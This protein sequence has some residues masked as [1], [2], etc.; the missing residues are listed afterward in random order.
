MLGGHANEERADRERREVGVEPR[1]S[2][3]HERVPDDPPNQA[4][5]FDWGDKWLN[6]EE[7]YHI[8]THTDL[9][10]RVYGFEKY[11][12]KTHPESTYT[13]PTSSGR[14]FYLNLDG[15]IYFVE[16]LSVGSEFGF[17]RVSTKKRYKWYL[18]SSPL[19][20]GRR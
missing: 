10:S 20:K 15:E 2:L 17:P 14:A 4:V 8:L 13:N 9:Y 19:C 18:L 1:G 12:P 5:H 3:G 16:G 7:Y 11:P 6:G